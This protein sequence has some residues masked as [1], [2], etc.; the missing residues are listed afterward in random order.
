MRP[1]AECDAL[2]ATAPSLATRSFGMP[3]CDAAPTRAILGEAGERAATSRPLEFACGCATSPANACSQ[4]PLVARA[5]GR[6]GVASRRASVIPLDAAQIG[7]EPRQSRG[8]TN[9][10]RKQQSWM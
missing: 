7:V 10:A 4:A 6:W 1:Y 3:R 8:E 2:H 9:T 5:W